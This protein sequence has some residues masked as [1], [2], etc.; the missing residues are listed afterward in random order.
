MPRPL[1]LRLL[2][3][4]GLGAAQGLMGWLMVV[5]G[6]VDWPSVSHFRLAAHLCLALVI[7]S[8]AVWIAR[9]ME[10]RLHA[11]DGS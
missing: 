9:D 3:L 11:A 6:L 7:V 8:V 5:S 1:L 10:V 4:F 2:A